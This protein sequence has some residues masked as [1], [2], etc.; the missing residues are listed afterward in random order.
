MQIDQKVLNHWGKRNPIDGF[1]SKLIDSL[2]R[3]VEL[4]RH[5]CTEI[6][7][8]VNIMEISLAQSLSLKLSRKR[9]MFQCDKLIGDC[10]KF[11]YC[12]ICCWRIKQWKR[13]NLPGCCGFQIKAFHLKVQF[14]IWIFVFL[15][16]QKQL[17]FDF[18][19]LTESN[20]IIG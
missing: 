12:S 7:W 14:K 13:I 5:L 16:T 4:K 1:R 6:Q 15:K 10:E 18:F 8:I 19:Y 9:I 3:S 20:L 2:S 17:F 11:R